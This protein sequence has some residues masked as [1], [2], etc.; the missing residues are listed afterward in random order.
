VLQIYLNQKALEFR[1]LWLLKKLYS[2]VRSQTSV[3][4]SWIA[5]HSLTC[6]ILACYAHFIGQK[7]GS[8]LNTCSSDFIRRYIEHMASLKRKLL[9]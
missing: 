9:W 6:Y 8:A 1:V 4:Q 2:Q 5:K 3:Y 7:C